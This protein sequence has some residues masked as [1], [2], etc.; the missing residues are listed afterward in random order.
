MLALLEDAVAAAHVR[1]HRRVV[2]PCWFCGYRR[3]SQQSGNHCGH[4][5]ALPTGKHTP[6]VGSVVIF[7]EKLQ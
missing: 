3:D 7:L 2:A 5:P 1:I 6:D 4:P